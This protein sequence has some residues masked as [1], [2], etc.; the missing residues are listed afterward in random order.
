MTYN[1]SGIACHTGAATGRRDWSEPAAA[2]CACLGPHHASHDALRHD[3]LPCGPHASGN[4]LPSLPPHAAQHRRPTRS[5][6][7]SAQQR[8]S[9]CSTAS[10][11]VVSREPLVSPQVRS[12]R[13]S[14]VVI[15]SRQ[16]VQ[17]PVASGWWE[18][19]RMN[20]AGRRG[21]S[22][23][24]DLLLICYCASVVGSQLG[25]MFL[26]RLA[27]AALALQGRRRCGAYRENCVGARAAASLTKDTAVQ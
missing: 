15:S 17:S 5:A 20:Q 3:A 21:R 24:F 19:C 1:V 18:R 26:R 25:Q 9:R 13:R 2:V 14:G 22:K 4:P 7:A 16:T 27:E 8:L 23:A 11:T 12:S 6:G 10:R